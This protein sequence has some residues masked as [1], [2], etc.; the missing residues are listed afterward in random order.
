MSEVRK[1]TFETVF[2]ASG[3][4][5]RDRSGAR[6]SYT[7]EELDAARQTA[8][9]EGETSAVVQAEARAAAALEAIA[10]DVKLLAGSLN[11]HRAELRAEAVELSLC[12]ART[13]AAKA[14]DQFPEEDILGLFDE[15]SDL[16]RDSAVVR[17]K[18]PSDTIETLRGRLEERARN[19][20]LSGSLVVAPLD[21]GDTHH[22]ELTWDAGGVAL[23]PDQA[24]SAVQEAADRWLAAS[25]SDDEQLSLFD[26]LPA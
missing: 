16:L 20:G 5:I 4:I 21:E 24:L 1:Y 10:A 11:T 13:A 3:R 22:A 7:P 6:F 17:I 23:A 18:A 12:A 2:D 25:Q 19:A 15:V 9:N 8:F 26:P 14:L